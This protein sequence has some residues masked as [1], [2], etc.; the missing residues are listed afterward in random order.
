MKNKGSSNNC[1]WAA[2]RKLL[3]SVKEGE[4]GNVT[5]FSM[6]PDAEQK[7]K[8]SLVCQ[9]ELLEVPSRGKEKVGLT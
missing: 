7:Q 8:D 6:E 2:S 1:F 4:A 9:N 5:A 3:T